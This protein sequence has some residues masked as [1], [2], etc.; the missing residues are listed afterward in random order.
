MNPKIF[1]KNNSLFPEQRKEIRKDRL[2]II[3]S[4]ILIGI[5]FT[6]FPMPFPL[7]LFFAF[8]PYIFVL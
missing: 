8:I 1:N 7:F 5:S 6:P 2:L 4:G 3:L